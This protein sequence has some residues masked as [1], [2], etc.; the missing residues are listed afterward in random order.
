MRQ[1]IIAVLVL[2]I[3]TAVSARQKVQDT[4]FG[5][6][7]GERHEDIYELPELKE[8]MDCATPDG[9]GRKNK[10]RQH[11]VLW[12]VDFGGRRWSYMDYYFSPG[13][14]FY[15]VRAYKNYDSLEDAQER[16]LPLM[17]D[18]DMKYGDDN[19][20]VRNVDDCMEDD[21]EQ[22]VTY[23]D[24][25]GRVCKL[26]IYYTESDSMDMYYY[27]MLYYYDSRLQKKIEAEFLNEL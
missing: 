24:A 23:T 10:P 4:F 16:Y 27:V 3:A 7:F 25:D 26:S 15:K 8:L 20:I 6:K 13:G 14:V 21:R 17:K 12:E 22:S 1:I 18:L 19:S 5:L 11:E 9:M 2:S